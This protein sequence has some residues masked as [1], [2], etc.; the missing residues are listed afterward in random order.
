M[1][2]QLRIA[3]GLGFL[4]SA[5]A[6]IVDLD[7]YAFGNPSDVGEGDSD[8]GVACAEGDTCSAPSLELPGTGGADQAVA[9]EDSILE[10]SSGLGGQLSSGNGGTNGGGTNGLTSAGGADG[11]AQ[12]GNA[13]A[14]GV[15]STGG[16]DGGIAAPVFDPNACDFADMQGCETLTC[17][18]ACPPNMGTYCLDTCKL[19]IQCVSGGM[20]TIT[21]SDPLCGRPTS[22]LEENACTAEVGTGGG[23]DS[24]DPG[25]PSYKAR[26]FVECACTTPRRS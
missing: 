16:A 23:V 24:I 21:A 3:S 20:C 22:D 1:K 15:E 19:I 9:R 6:A 2:I 25:S 17:E 12:G 18:Q 4:L 26:A 14:S 8:A 10:G 11:S 7:G 5:C 13:G